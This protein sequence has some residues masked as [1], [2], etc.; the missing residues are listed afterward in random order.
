[1]TPPL[2]PVAVAGAPSVEQE[3][4]TAHAANDPS[5]ISQPSS[6]GSLGASGYDPATTIIPGLESNKYPAQKRK[7]HD[8]DAPSV[9]ENIH[10]KAKLANDGES[11]LDPQ[12]NIFSDMTQ[13]LPAEVWHHIFTFLPPRTLGSLLLVNKLFHTHLDPASRVKASRPVF[14]A[15]STL[16][17]LKPDAIW[18]ASRRLFWP[19]MPVPLRGRSEVDMWRL[20]CTRTCQFCRR[21]DQDEVG[22][23]Q[24]KWHNG[25][26]AN[27][28]SPV[29]PFFI[30][31]CGRCLGERSIKENDLV[32]S[33]STPY[34]LLSGLPMVVLTSELCTIPPQAIR[35]GSIPLNTHLSKVFWQEHLEKIKAELEAVVKL[36]T[37]AAEEWNKGL[38][39]R[40]KGILADSSRWEKWYMSGGVH[41]MRLRDSA[42]SSTVTSSAASPTNAKD[43]SN[44]MDKPGAVADLASISKQIINGNEQTNTKPGPLSIPP[45][46]PTRSQSQQIRTR[47]DV[48]ELRAKRRIE[49]ERRA[50]QLQ[51]PIALNVLAH[52][53]SFQG[54]LQIIAPFD[55]DAWELLKPRLLA[56]REV[57]EKRER[58]SVMNAGAHQDMPRNA[59]VANQN[60]KEVTDEEW[61][62]VQGPL[63]A[64]IAGFADE[65]IKDSWDGGKKV[66]KKN[67]AQFATEVLL[68][69]RRGFHAEVAKD[70]AAARAA[71]IDP[72]IDPPQGP[73]TQKLTIE[74]MKWIFDTKIRPLTD[75]HRKDL[76]LCS[77]C[78]G[79]RK[80]FGF[81]A[82]IQHYAAKHTGVLSKGNV[83][84]NWRAEWP[85]APIFNPEIRLSVSPPSVITESQRVSTVS[86]PLHASQSVHSSAPTTSAAFAAPGQQY[87]SVPQL[88]NPGLGT[89][90]TEAVLNV[91]YRKSSISPQYQSTGSS[92]QKQN[93]SAGASRPVEDKKEDLATTFSQIYCP[94][95]HAQ[96]KP[97]G[98]YQHT[99]S[100]DPYRLQVDFMANIV[101]DTW[102]TLS[103]VKNVPLSVKVCTV[104]HHI[105]KGYQQKYSEPAPF[106]TFIDGLNSHELFVPLRDIQNL[107][108]KTCMSSPTWSHE[109]GPYTLLG[110]TNHFYVNHGRM[111]IS[112]L[113]PPDDWRVDMV[114]LPDIGAL[115]GLETVLRNK[116]Q[117]L[118]LVSDALPWALKNKTENGNQTAKAR[119]TVVPLPI[120]HHVEPA[121]ATQVQ[122]SA[123][124]PAPQHTLPSKEALLIQD[125]PLLRPASVVYGKPQDGH[126]QAA[127]TPLPSTRNGHNTPNIKQQALGANVPGTGQGHST[128]RE[129]GNATEQPSSFT[130]FRGHH[131]DQVYQTG[132]SSMN[133][134]E[135]G[136]RARV[137]THIAPAALHF[138]NGRRSS[139]GLEVSQGGH[140]ESVSRSR[141]EATR[142]EPDY[143]PSELEL[144]EVRRVGAEGR[145]RSV[146]PRPI[147]R[148]AQ[149]LYRER[150]PRPAV[151]R[152]PYEYEVRYSPYSRHRDEPPIYPVPPL[153]A[154]EIVEVRDPQGD[155]FIRRP[156][157]LEETE[158]LT[159]AAQ[160]RDTS[161][162]YPRYTTAY[163]YAPPEHRPLIHGDHRPSLVKSPEY[164]DYDPR[165][166]ATGPTEGSSRHVGRS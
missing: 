19:R 62:E 34:F 46:P 144:V 24:S 9:E 106:E 111:L 52:I 27:G 71:G 161:G 22:L 41:Q 81:E 69:V 149:P 18:Q 142:R 23:P 60:T 11:G 118:Q 91:P 117:A 163:E 158:V 20:A 75:R 33:S 66:K 95:F 92:D 165:Y 121:I 70:A 113:A 44:V 49:I 150:S 8:H 48:A 127:Y 53:P 112:Q 26:G 110:L 25:P 89:C 152:V 2:D 157:R 124:P 79:S 1:M 104:V 166:P 140:G 21:R 114:W 76:F 32:L 77:G 14:A 136:Q 148:Y 28:V 5:T 12:S 65:I 31:S 38:E 164:E 145:R 116:K 84:V 97:R 132:S 58:S 126:R 135:R 120:T 125:K 88:S 138:D 29:F 16:P 86:T 59:A 15:P 155:Y 78:E 90:N 107:I 154:Y 54:A 40:G 10:K 82:I 42:D 96:N 51:P 133:D 102:N 87:S 94:H 68:Y 109:R 153:A 64:R 30:V 151:S 67:C 137:A 56:Q 159:Y 6:D 160:G 55:D 139:Y 128:N 123:L 50:S 162:W 99:L 103:R 4:Q 61:N 130:E 129:L 7:T 141:Q 98:G 119:G 108:C 73:W 122:T 147:Y 36:G 74:N 43:L 35:T 17:V 45:K 80:F 37:A 39:T 134:N 146:S 63:R 47:G 143:D 105:A 100:G 93:G 72:I 57:A 115:V 13:Q 101:K 131:L 3:T 85:E 156:I 83:V